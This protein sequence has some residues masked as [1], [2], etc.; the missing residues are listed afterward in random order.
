MPKPIDK[1]DVDLLR[2]VPAVDKDKKGGELRALKDEF[3]DKFLPV[4]AARLAHTRIA[5]SRQ[6][7]QIPALID[8]KMVYQLCFAR[9]R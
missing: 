6:I 1:F 8:E 7:D 3:A 4:L 5:V 2:L 9:S